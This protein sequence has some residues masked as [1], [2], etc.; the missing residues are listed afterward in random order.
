MTEPQPFDPRDDSDAAVERRLTDG[1][2]T[3]PL[4]ERVRERLRAAVE[5]AWRAA[6]RSPDLRPIRYRRWKWAAAVGLASVAAAT[7]TLLPRPVDEPAIVGSLSRLDGGGVDRRFSFFRHRLLKLGDPLR[8]G[9]TVTAHGPALVALAHG[10]TLRI[11]AN[12]VIE[13]TSAAEIGLA[14]GMIY[15]DEPA[16]AVPAGG[17]NVATRVGVVEHLGTEFEVLSDS[18]AVRIRVR[19][20]RV[21]LLGASGAVEADAGTELLARPNGPVIKRTVFTYG[22]EWMWAAALAPDYEIEGRPLVDFLAWASRELGRGV[23]FSDAHAR[24]VAERTILHGSILGHAPLEALSNVLATTSLTYE[25]R[26][27]TIRIR[28]RP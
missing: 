24:E 19:E 6:T 21:R 15:L 16:P 7:L 1:L 28:S 14:R 25:L 26:G 13:V 10:G 20:G 9:D 22:L 11:A 17:L 8:A 23:E 5:G 2:R 12:T 18:Q 27:D 3:S 4:D